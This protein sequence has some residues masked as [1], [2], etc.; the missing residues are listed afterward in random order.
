MG[1]KVPERRQK[2]RKYKRKQKSR[3][4]STAG[5]E[6]TRHLGER[7]ELRRWGRGIKGETGRGGEKGGDGGGGVR[8]RRAYRKEVGGSLMICS[9]NQQSTSFCNFR[10][11]ISYR[12]IKRPRSNF[13]F[14][15]N[16]TRFVNVKRT[17]NLLLYYF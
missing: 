7:K 2:L 3:K 17:S 14:P 9:Q 4:S 8:R 13:I 10:D 16:N 5:E 1:K 12:T 15:F 11:I 6:K